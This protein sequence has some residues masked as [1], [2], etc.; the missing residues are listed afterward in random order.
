MRSSVKD[1]RLKLNVGQSLELSDHT[2][3]TAR[4][5][6]CIGSLAG[7][8]ASV[9]C[10]NTERT[11]NN[12]SS[13]ERGYLKEFYPLAH[14]GLSRRPNGILCADDPFS[15][16]FARDRDDYIRALHLLQKR[17]F[18]DRSLIRNYVQ[19]FELLYACDPKEQS[20]ATCYVWSLGFEGTSL[21]DYLTTVRDEPEKDALKKVLNVLKIT[22][23]MARIACCL[24]M[25]DLVHQDLKPSNLWIHYKTDRTIDASHVSLLDVD[26]ICSV[27]DRTAAPRGSKGF[28]ANDPQISI[29]G[30]IKSIGATL[31]YALALSAG[32]FSQP[33]H[34]RLREL[35]EHSQ[36]LHHAG[37]SGNSEFTDR[38][39]YILE[40]CLHENPT[41]RFRNCAE[42]QS[43]L[44]KLLDLV[45]V[46]Q[47]DD[48]QRSLAFV[49]E[50]MTGDRLKISMLTKRVSGRQ[51]LELQFHDGK[52][53]LDG[54]EV[55]SMGNLPLYQKNKALQDLLGQH[56]ALTKAFLQLSDTIEAITDR[57]E[58][59]AAKQKLLQIDTQRSSLSDRIQQIQQDM[60]ALIFRLTTDL[61]S[62]QTMDWRAREA[63]LLLLSGDYD[64]ARSA[65]SDRSWEQRIQT[66]KGLQAQINEYVKSVYRDVIGEQRMLI[67][68]IRA[69]GI[70]TD[71][72]AEITTIYE[73]LVPLAEEQLMELDALHDYAAFLSMQNQDPAAIPVAE[74][75]RRLYRSLPELPEPAYT[76]LLGL[77]SLL[78]LK[79]R[80]AEEAIAAARECLDRCL[81]LNARA[82]EVFSDDLAEAYHA[83]AICLTNAPSSKEKELQEAERL[84]QNAL[85]LRR[86][87]AK[88]DSVRYTHKLA[89]V[90]SS[91]ATFLC[92]VKGSLSAVQK[93]Y[94]KAI[95]LYE[96]IPDSPNRESLYSAADN[97]HNLAAF[98]LERK[99]FEDAERCARDA[100]HILEA[101]A[102]S[103]PCRFDRILA[104]IYSLL[105][106]TLMH[107][108]R[109][110]E[111]EEYLS[112]AV[113]IQTLL[114]RHNPAVEPELASSCLNFGRLLIAADKADAASDVLQTAFDLFR[115]LLEDNPRH[116]VYHFICTCHALALLSARQ[117][118]IEDLII[119]LGEIR[120]ALVK[121]N[122]K[123]FGLIQEYQ[124]SVRE[125]A[126]FIRSLLGADEKAEQLYTEILRFL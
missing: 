69:Q 22:L 106:T 117:G 46:Y 68:I 40:S 17:C 110:D 37:V 51:D 125:Q 103:N 77:L 120:N 94:K 121:T 42:L 57:Q 91:Y 104:L 12:G 38:L 65:V 111:A 109:F 23:E 122:E 88:E 102:A 29:R 45:Q 86:R 63:A 59:Q 84:Y 24:H 116:Y 6:Y 56:D 8:G 87:L 19:N 44:E 30:D 80:R 70:T 62:G 113:A 36:L 114:A 83:L 26:T 21:H 101:P 85:A 14:S 18:E 27:Y 115:R 97:Y 52:V 39:I 5:T 50:N 98:F 64:A 9:L 4:K 31:Y 47:F 99:Q 13:R 93:K 49:Y 43:E 2:D 76:N 28:F 33:E 71:S 1:N 66:A 123:G 124:D 25:E 67:S 108:R 53:Y 126:S 90:V 92:S 78:Y 105:G 75:L 73:A 72:A 58:R 107:L 10:Y 35:V 7:R 61:Q 81:A 79:L 41:A 60:F 95:A 15:A 112:R 34:G 54:E 82:P 100:L 3:G 48:L 16:A 119:F 11:W 118:K 96:S 32:E 74:K 55:M 20:A 89:N